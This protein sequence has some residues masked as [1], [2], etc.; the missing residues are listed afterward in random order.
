MRDSVIFRGKVL[1]VFSCEEV[2]QMAKEEMKT[3]KHETNHVQ[4]ELVLNQHCWADNEDLMRKVIDFMDEYKEEH[5]GNCT[6][7]VKINQ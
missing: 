7:L 4:I 5:S 3:K 6:L 2:T 1:P